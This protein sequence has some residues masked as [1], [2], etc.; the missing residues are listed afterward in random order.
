MRQALLVLFV[1]LITI[2]CAQD[3][4]NN[5]ESQTRP[6]VT[7]QRIINANEEP[8][9]WLSHGRTYNEQRFSP[10]NS[11]NA[12]TVTD[13]GLAWH[14]DI[15]TNRGMQTTPLV[16]DGVMYLTAAWS[17]VYALDAVSGKLLWKHDP[18]VPKSWGVYACC[19]VV[20]VSEVL[21]P[22]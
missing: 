9:N 19:D 18:Q 5:D 14:Y 13:L 1:L 12:D 22:P 15:D 11:I 4:A 10:L 8:G 6:P 16:A 21:H 3:S 2:A 7:G 20:P 17:V